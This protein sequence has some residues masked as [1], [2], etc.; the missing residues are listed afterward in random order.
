MSNSRDKQSDKPRI[1]EIVEKKREKQ[2]RDISK[3]KRR[4]KERKK[5]KEIK[6]EV[7]IKAR[8]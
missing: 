6:K 8:K 4:E 2:G 3:Q 7:K 1:N 5:I